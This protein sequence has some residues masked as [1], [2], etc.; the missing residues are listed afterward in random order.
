MAAAIANDTRI[1]DCPAEAIRPEANGPMAKPAVST[2]PAMAA[3]AGPLR[4]AGPC[5]A[6]ADRKAH[7]DSDNHAAHQKHGRV[8]R[9]QHRHGAQQCGRRA[10]PRHWLTPPCVRCSPADEQP[11][12][13]AQ[14]IDAE[15]RVHRGRAQVLLVADRGEQSREMVGGPPRRQ[16]N[17]Q[18]SGKQARHRPA[19]LVAP[20]G[21][22]HRRR[23]AA[24]SHIRPGHWLPPQ[25]SIKYVGDVF[26][27]ECRR[28][29]ASAATSND[30]F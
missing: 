1:P 27:S 10:Q 25:G 22:G 2:A 3:P 7:S 26:R 30:Q 15:H 8:Q 23:R 9:K 19:T 24:G 20:F 13:Q 21:G 28:R 11:G 18:H 12:Q 5:G 17:G 16:Q 4:S 6:G 14:R 29:C